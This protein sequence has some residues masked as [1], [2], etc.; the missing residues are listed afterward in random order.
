MPERAYRYRWLICGLLFLATAVNY[1]DRQVLS[2]LK[3]MLDEELK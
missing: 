2:L 1:V 3:P